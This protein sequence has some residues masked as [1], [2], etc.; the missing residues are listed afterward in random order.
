[1]FSEISDFLKNQLFSKATCFVVLVLLL[2]VTACTNTPQSTVSVTSTKAPTITNT[3]IIDSTKTPTPPPTNTS[4][5]TNTSTPEPTETPLPTETPTPSSLI[6]FAFWD[7]EINTYQLGVMNS[8]GS[9][10]VEFSSPTFT[11]PDDQPP[12]YLGGGVDFSWS[13]DGSLIA[14][15]FWNIEDEISRL[16][17]MNPDGLERV[18]SNLGIDRHPAGGSYSYTWSPDSSQI[19]FVSNKE[20]YITNKDGTELTQVEGI[21]ELLLVG[22]H[23]VYSPVW[24]PSGEQILFGLDSDLY[25]LSLNDSS[26]TKIATDPYGGYIF[27]PNWSPDGQWIV[28]NSQDAAVSL[29]HNE[30]PYEIQQIV[31]LWSEQW[32]WSP[33]AD[34]ILGNVFDLSSH[35]FSDPSNEPL[36][37]EPLMFSINNMALVQIPELSSGDYLW[38]FSPDGTKIVFQSERDG[39]SEI[40][41]ANV[42]GSNL[43]Q[44]THNDFAEKSISWS[45]DGTKILFVSDQNG[46]HEIYLVNIDGS[47]ELQ[48]TETSVEEFR[49][50][51]QPLP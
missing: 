47:G 41:I 28:V 36:I 1:M 27:S 7:E 25:I 40:F 42:D 10:R 48:L 8:D 5:P 3:P 33:D 43:I 17:V 20:L 11:L 37:F 2:G 38:G 32:S 23:G 13:P 49:A 51:W 50:I 4:I 46:S 44:L 26:I 19:A 31:S 16:S 18:E 39:N 35:D 29:I 9:N 24:S 22:F 6:A 21:T 14:S 45:P 30:P 15:V 12:T 34:F